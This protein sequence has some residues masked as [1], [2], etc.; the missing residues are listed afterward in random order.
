MK[1]TFTVA[2]LFCVF[3]SYAVCKEKSVIPL[4][5]S[6]G[7]SLVTVRIGDLTIPRIL[8]DTGFAFDG[9]MVYNPAYQDSMDLTGAFEARIPGAGSG[10]PAKAAVVDSAFFRL[11]D[12]EMTGQRL[13]V[14]TSDTYKGFPSNGIIGYSIFGHYV[15]EFDYD[16]DI[17]ILHAGDGFAPDG[18]WTVVPLYF[19]DNNIP[20]LDIAVVVEDEAPVPI[21][22]YIDYASRDAIELLE[23]PGMKYGL[24]RD[25]EEA[26]LGRG[27]SGD[28]YGRTG[29]V[30]RVIIGGH[31]LLDVSAAIA[32]AKVRSKQDNADAV[33]GCGALRRFNLIFDYAG[34]KLYLKPNSHFDEPFD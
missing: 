26:H 10:E 27:L 21:S 24:P 9:L 13:I 31:G 8:L 7:V 5:N 19:K 23:R 33:L 2:L 11:G 3:N 18:T 17:M 15:T 30:A 25:T 28:I 14:L 16:R 29:R 4:D 1:R 12:Q 20:W 6:R 32:D 34:K 22:V